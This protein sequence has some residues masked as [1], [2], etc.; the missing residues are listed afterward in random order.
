MPQCEGLQPNTQTKSQSSAETWG[1]G[2][3]NTSHAPRCKL[4]AASWRWG[5]ERNRRTMKTSHM[6]RK[7]LVCLREANST[8]Q[9]I[10][11]KSPGKTAQQVVDI[12]PLDAKEHSIRVIRDSGRPGSQRGPCKAGNRHGNFLSADAALAGQGPPPMRQWICC[13]RDTSR[14]TDV[15]IRLA[16]ARRALPFGRRACYGSGQAHGAAG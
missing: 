9:V 5:F 11:T 7:R 15:R 2:M 3:L 10:D 12:Q 4:E 14:P 13:F 8:H 6:T 1:L 16:I